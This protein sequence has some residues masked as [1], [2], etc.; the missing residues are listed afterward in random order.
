MFKPKNHR[1]GFFI[2]DMMYHFLS[3]AL[4][5]YT[6]ISTF[7][8]VGPSVCPNAVFKTGTSPKQE[9]ATKADQSTLTS[10]SPN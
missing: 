6:S 3:Q 7:T 1:F 4:L 5:I 2:G 8:S 10:M 9:Y